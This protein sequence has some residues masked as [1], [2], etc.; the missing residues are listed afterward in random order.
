MGETTKACILAAWLDGQ[1]TVET[2]ALVF[3]KQR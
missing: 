1:M 3:N 2:H